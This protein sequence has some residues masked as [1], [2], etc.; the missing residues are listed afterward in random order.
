MKKITIGATIF[1]LLFGILFVTWPSIVREDEKIVPEEEL[2][3]SASIG[4]KWWENIGDELPQI[5]Q[6]G[7]KYNLLKNVLPG[8]L[9]FEATGFGGLTGHILI[10]EGVFHDEGFNADYVRV[11]EASGYYTSKSLYEA[12]VYRSVL[13]DQRFSE[14][15]DYI[16]RVKAT[17]QQRADAVE[18]A[19]N[20]L[21]KP[22]SFNYPKYAT[23]SFDDYK[24]GKIDGWYC[25]EIGWASWYSV[26][27]NTRNACTIG[28]C[29]PATPGIVSPRDI[30]K[31]GENDSMILGY[32]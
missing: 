5:P 7:T 29:T 31:Y 13:D 1:V 11:I 24:D 26:G 30:T 19:K 2:H 8:D 18:Y 25:S 20:Q 16:Y 3:A 15:E 4:Q 6:Y 10:V 9:I 12:K 21:G 22:Y 28:F 23:T 14:N 27:I 17:D 32:K